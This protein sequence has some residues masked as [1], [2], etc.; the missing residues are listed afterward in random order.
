IPATTP[1]TA[2]AATCLRRKNGRLPGITYR[3]LQITAV[4]CAGDI[5]FGN[6]VA[7]HIRL[8]FRVA[9]LL[10]IRAL[11][12]ATIPRL[13][14]PG[15]EEDGEHL[16]V[17]GKRSVQEGPVPGVASSPVHI[18]GGRLAVALTVGSCKLWSRELFS[19][20]VNWGQRDGRCGV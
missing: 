18:S 17:A 12:M 20:L 8:F 7:I 6:S 19:A 1:H 14:P 11:A 16:L 5:K 10:V 9:L 4:L 3:R 13:W 2:A 15:T